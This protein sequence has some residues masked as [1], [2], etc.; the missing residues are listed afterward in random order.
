MTY[1]NEEIVLKG[2]KE[3]GKHQKT[4]KDGAV[5]TKECICATFI[6]YSLPEYRLL[7]G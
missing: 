4:G 5:R 6:W 3:Q 2:A 1:G 7:R